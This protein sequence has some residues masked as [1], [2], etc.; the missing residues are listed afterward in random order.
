M[1]TCTIE[2]CDKP[3][4]VKSR[5]WCAMHYRRWQVHG[6]TSIV[7][8]HRS[9]NKGKKTSAETRAKVSANWNPACITVERNRKIAAAHRGRRKAD[10]AIAKRSGANHYRWRGGTLAR[11]L[12]AR[13]W[14]TLRN[15]CLERDR[16][17]CQRC[18][19]SGLIA[20]HIIEYRD[21]GADELDNLLTLCRSCHAI[22][23]HQVRGISTSKS[24]PAIVEPT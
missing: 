17:L 12:N 1:A 8:P 15:Q 3:V 6:D 11:K 10:S 9:W 20:H 2:G 24:E 16:H 22:I 23:H 7:L 18:G 21:G 5:G 4:T 19:Q 13:E 14:R